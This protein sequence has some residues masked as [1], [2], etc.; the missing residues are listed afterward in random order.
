MVSYRHPTVDKC[1]STR[2]HTPQPEKIDNKVSEKLICG[3]CMRQ[4]HD[5]WKRV[6]YLDSR[7]KQSV[8]A[9]TISLLIGCP[10]RPSLVLTRDK[11]DMHASTRTE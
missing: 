8:A 7:Q 5:C 11:N 10:I 9:L 1:L 4:F 6:P 2:Y 3:G